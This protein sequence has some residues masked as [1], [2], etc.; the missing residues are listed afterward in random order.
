M[1]HSSYIDMLNKMNTMLEHA[2]NQSM[3][4]YVIYNI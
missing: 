4:I 1:T 2:F 3:V